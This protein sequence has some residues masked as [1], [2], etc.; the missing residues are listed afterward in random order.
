[1]SNSNDNGIFSG[2]VLFVRRV[3]DLILEISAV[4]FI[5]SFTLGALDRYVFKSSASLGKSFSA[6]LHSPIAIASSAAAATVVS[7]GRRAR[8]HEA[9]PAHG[10][11]RK[12]Y[13][14]MVTEDQRTRQ[15]SR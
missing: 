9:D 15:V 13:A 4:H 2:A 3:A 11:S 8:E 10:A 7:A 6:Y 12:S 1:M 14:E 5:V